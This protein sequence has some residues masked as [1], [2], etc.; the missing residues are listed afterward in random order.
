MRM[1]SP[2]RFVARG[3]FGGALGS[4]AIFLASVFYYKL[5]LGYVPYAHLFIIQG[6]PLVLAAGAL[7]GG[8]I[9]AAIWAASV[10]T[11]KDLSLPVRSLIG[12]ILVFVFA[13]IFALLA[14]G[15]GSLSRTQ[16][17]WWQPVINAFITGVLL[18]AVPGALSQPNPR[19]SSGGVNDN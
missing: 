8:L 13:L 4:F 2:L 17:V 5:T 9:G 11:N 3:A 12:F 10:T 1:R 18:G 15:E 7:A 14:R 6:L 19:V 16:V